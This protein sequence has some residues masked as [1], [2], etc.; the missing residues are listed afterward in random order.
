[1]KRYLSCISCLLIAVYGVT[2]LGCGPSKNQLAAE[3]SF[4]ASK[5]MMLKQL[6]SSP[7]FEMTASD[8]A[9]PIILENVSALR[10]FAAPTS[11]GNDTLTQYVH[12][13]YSGPWINLL[14]TTIGA[15]L[16]WLG[17]WGMVSAVAN[18]VPQTGNSSTATNIT[19][20]GDGNKTQIAGDMSISAT[21][22]N[23]GTVTIGSPSVIHD[24]TSVPTVVQQPAPIVV[25]NTTTTTNTTDKTSTTITP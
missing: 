1:M 19:T 4:Y 24:E 18:I 15:A 21:A 8:P 25:T 23:S 16:P 10:V 2:L 3:Q 6:G 5:V 9:K 13:D 7:I 22:G 17:A 20:R 14:S 11:G 12:R